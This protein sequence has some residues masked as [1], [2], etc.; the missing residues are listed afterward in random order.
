MDAEQASEW[1]NLASRHEIPP[2]VTSAEFS[3]RAQAK[4]N[5]SGLAV[6]RGL[7][8]KVAEGEG[9]T[10][11]V[12]ATASTVDLENET[13]SMPGTGL[14]FYKTNPVGFANHQAD[15]AGVVF[16]TKAIEAQ[17]DELLMRIKYAP[18][19]VSPLADALYQSH[20][21][22]RS[23]K[24]LD[25][26]GAMFS[27]RFQPEFRK[28]AFS[29][30]EKRGGMDFHFQKLWEVSDVGI[31]AMP[32]AQI[33][34]AAAAG[35]PMDPV[36]EWAHEI[37]SKD[38]AYVLLKRE[39]GLLDEARRFIKTL[40]PSAGLVA[41]EAPEKVLAPTAPE[42]ALAALVARI[43]ALEKDATGRNLPPEAG[44]CAAGLKPAEEPAAAEPPGPE[45]TE[46][47]LQKCADEIVAQLKADRDNDRDNEQMRLT[48]ACA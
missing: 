32:R 17:G 14:S 19:E 44:R 33:L 5:T 7:Q 38:P 30:N 43:D 40:D 12:T 36:M 8:T 41:I 25:D 27:I 26:S 37:V 24:A 18:K 46:A 10:F 34:R 15:A 6:T 45:F 21:W 39:E 35:V 23:E 31:G 11:D 20:L 9:R 4:K 48:G 28:D 42:A 2:S 47:E 29:F 22:R 13:V 16:L 1:E 3:R